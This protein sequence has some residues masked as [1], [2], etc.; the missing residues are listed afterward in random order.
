MILSMRI[1]RW[2]WIHEDLSNVRTGI[3]DVGYD[4][5][6][7]AVDLNWVPGKHIGANVYVLLSSIP[8]GR[9]PSLLYHVKVGRTKRTNIDLQ[10]RTAKA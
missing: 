9:F 6:D 1:L 10:S 5:P 3:C 8:I 4:H 2:S 7:L